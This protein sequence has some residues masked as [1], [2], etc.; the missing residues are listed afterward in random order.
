MASRPCRAAFRLLVSVNAFPAR[1]KF[2]PVSVKAF[3]WPEISAGAV[4]IEG[5]AAAY[6]RRESKNGGYIME[7]VDV[8][9]KGVPTAILSMFKGFCSIEGKNESEGIIDTMIE[10]IEKNIGGDKSNLN[11]IVSEYRASLKKK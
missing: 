1:I 11:K 3:A 5:C 8:L 9:V 2:E 6:A 10:H 4:Y 7:K